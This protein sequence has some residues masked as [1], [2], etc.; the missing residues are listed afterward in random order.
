MKLPSRYM[1]KYKVTDLV[2]KMRAGSLKERIYGTI[3]Y[4][5]STINCRLKLNNLL[6]DIY[7][8]FVIPTKVGIH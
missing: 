5:F 8:T 6:T 1:P 4:I 2:Q 3:E 7:P